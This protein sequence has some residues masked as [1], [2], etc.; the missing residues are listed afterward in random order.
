MV[1]SLWLV[2]IMGIFLFQMNIDYY[3]NVGVGVSYYL[4]HV[5][6]ISHPINALILSL[7]TSRNPPSIVG[8]KKP[9]SI[10][11]IRL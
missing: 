4:N 6:Q 3:I 1:F 11:E 10:K 2:V 9:M 7:S 5:F 8:F